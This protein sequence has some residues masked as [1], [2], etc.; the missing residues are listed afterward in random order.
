MK[1]RIEPEL[2]YNGTI[3][4][5]DP[6]SGERIIISSVYDD[7][8]RTASAEGR[9]RTGVTGAMLHH[10][11]GE[12]PRANTTHWPAA[13]WVKGGHTAEANLYYPK[14]PTNHKSADVFPLKLYV[15]RE[16]QSSGYWT[17][18]DTDR[19]GVLLMSG[20]N[21]MRRPPPHEC[22]RLLLWDRWLLKASCTYATSTAGSPAAFAAR[23]EMDH[24]VDQRK[25]T[26]RDIFAAAK[27]EKTNAQQ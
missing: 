21:T 25:K 26:I 4:W 11:S 12:R 6:R 17:V 19:S 14:Q 27:R 20:D 9:L 5:T 24:A 13:D 3:Q 1:V 10:L 22:M 23:R 18:Y 15:P 7:A 16:E 8:L 2:H